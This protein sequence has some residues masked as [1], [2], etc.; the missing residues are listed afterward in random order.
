MVCLYHSATGCN[1]YNECCETAEG[2]T[3]CSI[4]DEAEIS[5][6]RDALYMGRCELFI[7]NHPRV[8]PDQACQNKGDFYFAFKSL[9]ES[10]GGISFANL[11]TFPVLAWLVE[12]PRSTED[13]M[14]GD[15]LH[16]S[17]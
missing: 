4:T 14:E 5:L 3:H 12:C 7:D 9:T 16:L 15:N 8:S 2:S 10:F 17:L 1:P 11:G 6:P 13:T